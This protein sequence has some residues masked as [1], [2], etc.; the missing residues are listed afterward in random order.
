MK[1]LQPILVSLLLAGCVATPSP[2]PTSA[3]T[4]LDAIARDYVS[5]TLEMGE[6]DDGYVDA[7]YGPAE[8]REAARSNPRPLAELASHAEG[9]HGRLLAVDPAG[10]DALSR[11]RR[12][13]LIKQLVAARTRLRILQ[14]EGLG[15]IE[16][17]QGLYGV[18]PQLRPLSDYDPALERID[19]LV[20][21]SGPIVDR[22]E[23]FRNRFVIPPDRLDRVMRAAIDECRRRTVRHIALPDSERFTLEFVTDKS[24][25]GYNWYQGDYYSLIQVNTDLP[26]RIDRAVDLG[27]HEGY[28]GH[29]AFNALL[30]QKLARGR[31]WVEYM[32]YPLYSPQSFIAE[33]SA[34]YGVKLAFPGPERLEFETR[35]LYPLAGLSTE[36]ATEYLALEEALDVLEGARFTI[37]R[38]YLEQ[39][40]GRDRA[41]ELLQRYQLIPRARAEQSLA[42]IDQYRSYVINYGLGAEMVGRFI[43][44]QG[45]DQAG[46]WAAMARILSEPTD[47]SHLVLTAD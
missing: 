32:V 17:A 43:E 18:T 39:R 1:W 47:P 19:Q 27:C 44:A 15:F 14:G 4:P 13:S 12:E 20:P 45:D 2:Q 46:R 16:E 40:I 41:I 3:P 30:E 31:G 24:W 11:R 29:H 21:G 5:L 22:L 34:N 35:T 25:S 33:G 8:W 23:A 36:G 9:L 38:D 26:I 10:L 6:R 42:F 37:A 7:Y 28:P